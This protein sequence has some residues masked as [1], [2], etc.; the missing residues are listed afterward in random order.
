MGKSKL[1]RKIDNVNRITLAEQ[2]SGQIGEDA[3]MSSVYNLVRSLYPQVQAFAFFNQEQ[4]ETLLLLFIE[5]F[6]YYIPYNVM[7]QNNQFTTF[8]I[9]RYMGIL[10]HYRVDLFRWF[11]IIKQIEKILQLFL[12]NKTFSQNLDWHESGDMNRIFDETRDLTNTVT[13]DENTENS[14]MGYHGDSFNPVNTNNQTNTDILPVTAKQN[15]SIPYNNLRTVNIGSEQTDV[16]SNIHTTQNET[17]K[18]DYTMNENYSKK[19]DEDKSY[20]DMDMLNNLQVESEQ[21]IQR[22]LSKCAELFEFIEE[23]EEFNWGY[24]GINVW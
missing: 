4:F 2:I 19:G 20:M 3:S 6:K 22:W 5:T 9:T 23:D 10:T 24:K 17:V 15:N 18:V 12:L 21:F 11:E 1:L 8:F 16:N 7:V 14:N 13:T